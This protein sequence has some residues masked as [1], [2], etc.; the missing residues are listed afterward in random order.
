ASVASDWV[1]VI[2]RLPG[3]GRQVVTGNC[4]LVGLRRNPQAEKVERPFAP[5]LRP[6]SAC[7]VARPGLSRLGLQ[8]EVGLLRWWRPD[9]LR[10]PTVLATARA[11]RYGA[12]SP[13]LPG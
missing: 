13:C 3:V 11:P 8:S 10:S 4:R 9:A 6:Q 1:V 12:A 7:A 2:A 5:V